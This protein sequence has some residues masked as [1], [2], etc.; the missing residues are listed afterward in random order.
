MIRDQR[1]WGR[2]LFRGGLGT[3]QPAY[4]KI[5]TQEIETFGLAAAGFAVGRD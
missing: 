1:A 2:L 4:L 3:I 5:I